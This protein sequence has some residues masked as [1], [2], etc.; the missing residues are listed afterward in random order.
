MDLTSYHREK[1]FMDNVRFI[2]EL[3]YLI[4]HRFF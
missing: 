1:E 4:V 3:S 2:I